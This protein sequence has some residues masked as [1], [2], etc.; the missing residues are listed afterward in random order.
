MRLLHAPVALLLALLWLIPLPGVAMAE[1]AILSFLSDVRVENDGTLTVTETIT[2]NAE[3]LRIRHGI[4]RDIPLLL[5]RPDGAIGT[6]DLEVVDVQ[7]NGRPEPWFEKTPRSGMVRI[8]IGSRERRIAPG[9]HSYR[10]TYR[11][12]RQI[13]FLDQHDELFWNVTGHDWAFPLRHA[14]VNV[15]LPE[16]ARILRHALYTGEPGSRAV[17]ARVVLARENRLV[18]ETTRPLRPGEGFSIVV[19]FPKGIVAPPAPVRQAWWQLRDLAG[20]LWF[21]AGTL[22]TIAWLFIAWWRHGRDPAPGAIFPRWKPPRGISPA[23]A[24]HL[25]TATKIATEGDYRAFIA[26]LVSLAM[27]GYIRMERLSSSETILERLKM[28][29]SSLPPD[30]T[31][32][33]RDIFADGGRFV[34][35]RENGKR[36]QEILQRF[37]ENLERQVERVHLIRNL[38]QYRIGLAL[39]GVTAL[40]V[41]LMAIFGIPSATAALGMM[42]F[43]F[44]VLVVIGIVTWELLQV[45]GW[46]RWLVPPFVVLLVLLG[47]AAYSLGIHPSPNEVLD[48]PIPPAWHNAMLLALVA[49]PLS[50]VAFWYLLPRPTA[51]GRKTLDALEGLRMFIETAERERL[52]RASAPW[53]E[54]PPSM[55]VELYERLLPWAIALGVEKPWTEAFR[56][57]LAR[58]LPGDAAAHDPVW[59]HGAAGSL[60]PTGHSIALVSALENGIGSAMPVPDTASSGFGGGGGVGG[61]GG[62]GG[63]GGW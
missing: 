33:M 4:Y 23:V 15:V 16:E 44:F 42:I 21:I 58:N 19:A 2:V 14:R 8:Y 34:I 9:V 35:S 56:K 37:H 40:G 60:V 45:K 41:G 1:E 39:G 48:S 5:R 61:G 26:A 54:N 57:W 25:T 12:T 24:H 36:L 51:V 63:G 20:P 6:A 50:L 3:G 11:I 10:I 47:Y 59:Y 13:R 52:N 38:W 18:A 46:G 32:L 49:L 29:D 17:H 55:S 22:A 62:G 53:S 43:G 30:E 27:Q 31:A 7:R 28:P